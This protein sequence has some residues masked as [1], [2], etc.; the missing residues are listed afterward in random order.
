MQIPF[1][2]VIAIP[3]AVLTLAEPSFAVQ[4][5]D[6]QCLLDL[7]DGA[8]VQDV[9]RK[10]TDTEKTAVMQAAKAW[11]SARDV[12]GCDVSGI[13]DFSKMF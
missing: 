4:A 8:G 9:T 10:L 3:I 11:P 6:N 7:G 5:R 13:T 1:R 12:T 2:T